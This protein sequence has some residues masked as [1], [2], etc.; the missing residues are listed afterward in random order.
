MR[1]NYIHILPCKNGDIIPGK[2]DGGMIPY[3]IAAKAAVG[4]D[5]SLTLSISASC[6]LFD[7]ALRF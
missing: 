7:F 5:P 6:N 1:A 4:F 2:R 3:C